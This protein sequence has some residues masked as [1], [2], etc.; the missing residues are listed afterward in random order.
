MKQ[1]VVRKKNV[2]SNA[3][4]VKGKK[5][6]VKYTFSYFTAGG[7]EI[8]DK[9]VLKHVTSLRVPPAYDDVKINLVKGN[10]LFAYG[11][12][13]AGR[14]QYIYNAGYVKKQMA[15]KYCKLIKFERKLPV[16]NERIN[17]LVVQ[18]NW[19][20]NKVIAI[21][22]RIILHCNFRVGN[23]IYR[24]KYNSFGITTLTTKHLTFKSDGTLRIK[25]VGKKGV[26]N[27]CTVR[28]KA[29]VSAMKKI[30][31]NN[32]ANGNGSD[33]PYFTY[34]DEET[35]KGKGK[36]KGELKVIKATDVNGFL[37]KFG[38]FTS[39]DYRTWAANI[40]LLGELCKSVGKIGKSK[41]SR[42]KD[43]KDIIE[44]VAVRL[45]HTPAIC[46]K[47]YID[48]DLLDMYVEKPGDFKKLV[49]GC[50][51]TGDCV[52]K[53]FVEFLHRKC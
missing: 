48:N 49:K 5:V 17:K 23:D 46:K 44:G 21:I 29:L 19:N 45:H 6:P 1:Y 35:G 26:V 37:G 47:S 38:Q 50:N 51:G 16:I 22:L 9:K 18:K 27:D 8:K 40:A 30:G 24:R 31:A 2:V 13:E 4:I 7:N 11:I 43:L 52:N 28:D 36:G 41:A 33:E 34:I 10:K 39:K 20:I 14:P 3:K 32:R 15:K 25:F 42:T 53:V 12:D